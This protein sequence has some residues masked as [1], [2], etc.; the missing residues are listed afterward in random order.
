[1]FELVPFKIHHLDKMAKQESNL[2]LNLLANDAVIERGLEHGYSF[3]GMM[4]GTPVVCGGIVEM[5]TDR[6][7]IWTVFDEDCKSNFIP[8]FRGIK[9]F[10]KEQPYRRVELCVPVN[11]DL[12]H[13]RAMMLGFKIETL[14]AR[15]YLPN[16]DDATLYSIVRS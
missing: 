15:K 10:L 7:Y 14:V 5:W 3:T 11:F 16:G 2:H 9:K 13:R 6:G 12:G 1:M 8:V 4:N